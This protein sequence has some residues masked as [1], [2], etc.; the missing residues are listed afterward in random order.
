M[1]E[2]YK[3]ST[4]PKLEHTPLESEVSHKGKETR[5]AWLLN[6]QNSLKSELEE[7]DDEVEVDSELHVHGGQGGRG[8]A[9]RVSASK[10]TEHAA[11]PETR[12]VHSALYLYPSGRTRLINVNARSNAFGS[13]IFVYMSPLWEDVS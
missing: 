2:N 12:A 3:R 4:G 1:K 7:D 8:R 11:E 5:A 10:R 6:V 9:G 13:S